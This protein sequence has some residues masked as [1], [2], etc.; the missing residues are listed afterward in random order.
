M[1]RSSEQD[2]S[3]T[4]GIESAYGNDHLL[5]T[6]ARSLNKKEVRVT[7]LYTPPKLRRLCKCYI[8]VLSFLFPL[9]TI[10]HS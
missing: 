5:D 6:D 4:A 2:S 1:S 7:L 3:S 8:I 10:Q 9:N